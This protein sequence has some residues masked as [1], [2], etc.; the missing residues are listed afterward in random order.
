MRGRTLFE[1]SQK[2]HVV[3]A[4]SPRNKA[5]FVAHRFNQSLLTPVQDFKWQ[6]LKIA[7]HPHQ[8]NALPN[9]WLQIPRS[10]WGQYSQHPSEEFFSPHTRDQAP[11]ISPQN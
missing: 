5:I 3:E 1:R 7:K 11:G 2:R 4:D 10:E 8:I 6:C 9:G